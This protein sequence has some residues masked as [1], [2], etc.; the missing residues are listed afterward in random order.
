MDHPDCAI[1]R[2]PD[3]EPDGAPARPV[4]RETWPAR[5]RRWVLGTAYALMPSR[6]A[7][8]PRIILMTAIFMI[9]PEGRERLPE[10]PTFYG[11]RGLVGISNDLSVG[12]LLWAYRRGYFPVSHIGPM[13]WWSP[14]ERAILVPE[15]T[16]ISHKMR[17]LMRQK[18]YRVTFD[19]DFAQVM[20]C[21]A[22]PREGK[23]PLTWIT[24]RIMNAYWDLH[25]AGYAHSVEVWDGEG[26][27]VGGL[28][29]VA[30]GGAF[31]GESQFSKVEHAS[32]IAGAVLNRHL[33]EWRFGFRDA[34]WLTPHLAS[35]GFRNVDRTTFQTMLLVNLVKPGR[36]GPWSVDETL[37]VADWKPHVEEPDLVEEA[38][39]ALASESRRL[40]S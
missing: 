18:K 34:K 1:E 22:Q 31:F 39:V 14:D 11:R 20:R 37:N 28:Y 3:R 7:L 6:I 13:K 24:P 29:G 23:T 8:M 36:S 33:A 17:K 5:L 25:Q 19:Q 32:K 15:E 9:M 38:E 40:A 30:I 2:A 12:N 16:H 21:C 10:E 26:N 4:F 27:L 35:L